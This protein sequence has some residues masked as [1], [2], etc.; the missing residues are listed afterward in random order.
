MD[1]D[2]FK[3][4]NDTY[5]HKVGDLVLQHFST[6]MQKDLRAH[7]TIGRI[8]GEEFAIFLPQ[9]TADEA[10]PM[11]ERFRKRV[12]ETPCPYIDGNGEARTI[13]YSGSF[14]AAA[15]TDGVWTLDTLFIRADEQLYKAKEQGRNCVVIKKL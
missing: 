11:I 6:L 14:G 2:H 9:T 7:D 15:V 5:G 1:L 10:Q 4:V 12:A 3:V 13:S 8:G